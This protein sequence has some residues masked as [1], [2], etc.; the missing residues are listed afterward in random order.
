MNWF[1]L[2]ID[3][4]A[5]AA[6]AASAIV[7]TEPKISIIDLLSKGG[8]L[9]IPLAILFVIAVFVFFERLIFIRKAST[10]DDNFMNIIRDN[11]FSGNVNAA[12]SMAKNTNNPLARM[13]DKGIQRIGKPIDAIEKSME[14][15]GKLEMYKM[16][17]NLNI[18]SL[19]AGIAPMFGFLGTIFGM[20][21]LFFRLASTGE[22]TIQSMADGIYTKLI[23][24]ALGLI[25]GLLA[26]IAYNYLNAQVDKTGNKME[27][28][29]AEFVD[30]LQ[31][32]TR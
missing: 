31:E 11:I 10:I 2:Q 7:Q 16:E 17:R 12:R 26:Y 29:S 6:R 25:I 4:S 22:F 32:P 21:Q 14:N 24:S 13:I 27:I 9:M 19:I 30:I 28:A 8:I 3:T 18:L 15:V 5:A 20:F 1:F 23:S